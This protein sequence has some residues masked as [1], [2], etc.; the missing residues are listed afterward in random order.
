MNSKQGARYIKTRMGN[1]LKEK[2]L[3]QNGILSQLLF[4]S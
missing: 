4:L 2:I 3:L 1:D